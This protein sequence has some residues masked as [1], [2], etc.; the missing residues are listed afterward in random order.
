MKK[1]L[2]ATGIAV[3]AFAA[4]AGAT[5]YTFSNNLTIGS[6]GADVTALQNT[7]MSAGFDIPAISSGAATTGY[8]GSQTKA[9]LAKYQVAKGIVSPGTGFFGPLTMKVINGGTVAVNNPV[10]TCPVGYTCTANPGTTVVNTGAGTE[11]TFTVKQA[12]QPANNTNVTSNVNVPVY[13]VE[14]KAQNSNMLVDRADLEFAVSVTGASTVT[15]NPATFV[16]SVSAYDGDT[17]LKTMPLSASDFT[18]DTSGLFYVRMTGIGFQ[19]PKDV[20]KVL[21]FKI[22]VTS[23]SSANTVAI[24]VKGYSGTT[25]NIRAVDTLG[26]QSYGNDSWTGTFTFKASNNATLTASADSNTPNAQT[27]AVNTS[28]G[29][30]GVT[31]MTFNLKS[32]IGN[33][34]LD[35]VR[36]YVKTDGGTYSAPT[37]IYLYDG[38][39]LVSSASY[40]AYVD[41]TNLSVPIGQDQTKTLTIKADFP[42]TAVGVA[43]T[44]ILTSGAES[45]TTMYDTADQTTK[46]VTIA[47]AITGNDVHLYAGSVGQVSLVSATSVVGAGTVDVASSSVSG[48][49]TLNIKANGGTLTKPVATDFAVWF[50][51]TTQTNTNGT[52]NGYTAATGISVTPSIVVSPNTTTVGDGS[53]YTVAISGVL[54]SSSSSF[55]ASVGS[56]Y[57]M[58]MAIQSTR[59]VI[60][61]NT[62]T[63]TWGIDNLYTPAQNLTKGTK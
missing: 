59:W 23:V 16:T 20:T 62:V 52:G 10:F 4:I 63:Q 45:N 50:A 55:G 15:V 42:S 1:V 31:M 33:S 39:T 30:Q 17:L 36:V 2:F 40:A 57:P 9:A 38:S 61:D 35:K 12:A 60:T 48:T 58:F 25:Q 56:S 49:I 13:G 54:P 21:T 53:S 27:I 43:S 18:K 3:L 5:G 14:I 7:L 28:N 11:G 51:S 46:E 47:S 32:T 34:Q 24:T 26:L 37:A 41:F 22:N 19:V 29:V 8:F 6:T 44:T